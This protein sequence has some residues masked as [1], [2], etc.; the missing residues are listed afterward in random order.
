MG[1]LVGA[2]LSPTAVPRLRATP[3]EWSQFSPGWF[4]LGG[5]RPQVQPGSPSDEAALRSRAVCGNPV[6][7]ALRESRH[8]VD[9][10]AKRRTCGVSASAN[11]PLR[12]GVRQVQ[13]AEISGARSGGM[14]GPSEAKKYLRA[15][16]ACGAPSA[17]VPW[18]GSAFAPGGLGVRLPFVVRA[19]GA[20]FEL[21]DEDECCRRGSESSGARDMDRG[22]PIA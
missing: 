5:G 1:V 2:L 11:V 21:A 13:L 10:V 6:A 4:V 8:I 9:C 7:A 19:V 17:A 15:R 12:N 3:W 22:A 20:N 16:V 18:V 14:N